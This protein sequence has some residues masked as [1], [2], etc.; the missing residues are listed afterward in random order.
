M[1]SPGSALAAIA[2]VLLLSQ[3]VLAQK[4]LFDEARRSQANG[5]FVSAE[6]SYRKFLVANPQS[7]PGW[8]NLGV[9]LAKQGRF[10]DAIGAYRSAL[11]IDPKALAALINMGLAYYRMSD[12]K[13]A[14]I[15]FEKALSQNPQDRRS[16]QLLAISLSQS[17][18]YSH[19]LPEYE[20]LMPSS[21]VSILIGLAS[22][23]KETGREADSERMLASVLES[24]AD[25]P[26]VYYLF[27]LAAYTRQDYPEAVEKLQK[28][29]AIA[30]AMLEPRFYLGA[31]YFKQNDLPAALKEWENVARSDPNYFPA[32]FCAGALL[33][34]QGS[35]KDAQPL[36]QHAYALK[37]QD[38]AVQL[39]LGKDYLD[40]EQP[41]KALPLLQSARRLDPES[42]PASFLLARTLK[43]LGRKEEAAVEFKRCK[44]LFKN[45]VNV[46]GEPSSVAQ[47]NEP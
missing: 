16:R 11:R 32:F 9:V 33:V 4:S 35:D 8:T 40:L 30:P 7:L 41:Q 5:D 36:L 45:G 6:R 39:A 26:Q 28:S 27:G 21:D 13:N 25:S 12:W 22:C 37:P 15:S 47:Q 3:A 38:R 31:T 18:D 2:V 43:E 14:A 1:R 42:Q 44:V 24:H 34:D 23:Y 19:A 17:G 20:A 46:L 10:T 29:L